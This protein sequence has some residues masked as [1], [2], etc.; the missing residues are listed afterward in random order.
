[1]NNLRSCSN[2]GPIF[3]FAILSALLAST[4]C[5]PPSESQSVPE[6][7]HHTTVKAQL[8]K[9]AREPAKKK[10]IPQVPVSACELD[11]GDHGLSLALSQEPDGDITGISMDMWR[12]V[13]ESAH[14]CTISVARGDGQSQWTPL[15]QGVLVHMKDDEDAAFSITIKPDRDQS[16]SVSVAGTDDREPRCGSFVLP[17]ELQTKTSADGSCALIESR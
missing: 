7:T 15:P 2:L 3:R 17:A 12:L 9:A 8:P 13:N 14:E 5:S 4:A 1:M 10:A 11:G 6:K 16:W